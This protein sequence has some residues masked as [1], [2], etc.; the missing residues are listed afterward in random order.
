V[1]GISTLKEIC[2][3]LP[4]FPLENLEFVQNAL[5]NGICSTSEN[6]DTNFCD[7]ESQFEH[8]EKRQDINDS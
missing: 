5:L 8:L 2:F 3:I 1:K 7:V 6:N 4:P